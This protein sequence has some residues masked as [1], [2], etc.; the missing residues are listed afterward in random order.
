MKL[1]GL[2]A[3]CALAGCHTLPPVEPARFDANLLRPCEDRPLLKGTDGKTV[4]KW[5]VAMVHEYELCKLKHQ[6]LIDA[7]KPAE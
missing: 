6:A 5:G 3:A 4:L 1:A 2:L 7:V